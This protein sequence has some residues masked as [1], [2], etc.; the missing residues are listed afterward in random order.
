MAQIH[1]SF[2]NGPHAEGTP[3]VLN[4]LER[5]DVRATFFVLGR[6]LA[7]P[8]GRALAERARDA[9]H[10]LGNHSFSHATPLGADPRADAVERELEATQRL[11]D[12][13]WSGPRWFR[14]FGGGGVL[15]SH[16]LSPAAIEWMRARKVSCVLWNSVPGDWNDPRGWLD[17]AVADARRLDHV[18]M[19]LHDILPEQMRRLDELLVRLK[20]DGHTF[21][22][23][24]PADCVPIVD[25]EARSPLEPLLSEPR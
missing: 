16:L 17:R 13:V 22:T 7:A 1:L 15:G 2:D 19:V 11:L 23:E 10:R 24:I 6:E 25:G 8:V 20:E 21:T 5:H 3:T 4:V 12:E 9:G 18:L 14:P